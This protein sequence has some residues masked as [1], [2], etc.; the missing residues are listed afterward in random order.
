MDEAHEVTEEQN[1][2]IFAA[3]SHLNSNLKQPMRICM[4]FGMDWGRTLY[5]ESMVL[6]PL[7]RQ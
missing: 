1:V 6:C 7:H 2:M 3:S 4:S 5:S